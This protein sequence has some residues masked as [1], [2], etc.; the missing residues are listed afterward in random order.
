M[1]YNEDAILTT[2]VWNHYTHLMSDFERR[3][4]TAIIGRTKAENSSDPRMADMLRRS[5]GRADD[6]AINSALQDGAYRFRR[7]VRDR[8]LT[9]YA[10]QVFINRCPACRRIVRIPKAHFCEWCGHTWYE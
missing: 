2:Y 7:Q 1:D 3:V 5:W 8:L 9:A 4:G 10:D 6:P